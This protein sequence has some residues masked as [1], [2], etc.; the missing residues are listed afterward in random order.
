M[1]I[2]GASYKEK[3][4]FSG[5]TPSEHYKHLLIKEGYFVLETNEYMTS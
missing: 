3:E 2:W 1:L 5:Q 4:T